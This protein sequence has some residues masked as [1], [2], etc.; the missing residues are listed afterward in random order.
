MRP[1]LPGRG[2]LVLAALS[3]LAL[4]TLRHALRAQGLQVGGRS[5]WIFESCLEIVTSCT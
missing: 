4:L 5:I 2:W 1:P 3:A